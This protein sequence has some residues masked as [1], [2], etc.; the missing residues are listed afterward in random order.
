M[1]SGSYTDGQTKA[2]ACESSW[3]SSVLGSTRSIQTMPSRRCWRLR[4]PSETSAMISGVSGADL[5]PQRLAAIAAPLLL[6]A[7]IF[8]VT[9]FV[10]FCPLYLPFGL[11]TRRKA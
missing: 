9:S 2:V 11:S 3:H 5:L 6:L 4:T 10:S 8:V 7:G 1:P